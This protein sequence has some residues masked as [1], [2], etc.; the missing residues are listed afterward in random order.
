MYLCSKSSRDFMRNTALSL[1]MTDFNLA[2]LTMIGEEHPGN[3]QINLLAKKFN[4]NKD[5][6]NTN[7]ETLAWLELYAHDV[8][9]L[10]Y[11]CILDKEPGENFTLETPLKEG[12]SNLS[13]QLTIREQSDE[14]GRYAEAHM[15]NFMNHNLDHVLDKCQ[16]LTLQS[17]YAAADVVNAPEG[18]LNIELTRK[19]IV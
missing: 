2:W 7:K 17:C 4:P 3:E 5:S 18:G 8:A 13:Q 14:F 1:H 10:V 6:K 16:C 15:T 12:F 9:K 11:K 19:K